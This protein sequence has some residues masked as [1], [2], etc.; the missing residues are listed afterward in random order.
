MRRTNK[1]GGRQPAVV[2]ETAS[3]TATDFSE[4]ST[5]APARSVSIPRLAYASR[6]WLPARML[7][8][9]CV[10][11]PQVRYPFPRLAYASRSW[12]R[13][14]CSVRNATFAMHKRTLTRAAGVSPPW[15]V[16]RTQCGENRPPFDDDATHE[17]ERR[18]SARRGTGNRIC[19][20]DRL[21]RTQHGRPSTVGFHPTAGL[22]QPLLVASADAVADVRFISESPL[23]TP[24]LAYTSRSWLHDIQRFDCWAY[25][26]GH[27]TSE[28]FFHPNRIKTTTLYPT[29]RGA[30]RT[31]SEKQSRYERAKKRG[32]FPGCS[33]VFGEAIPPTRFT[34]PGEFGS[35]G[36][37]R[38]QA[39]KRPPGRWL[40]P[41]IPATVAKLS[42]GPQKPVRF[43]TALF[44]ADRGPGGMIIVPDKCRLGLRSAKGGEFSL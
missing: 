25:P 24:R 27:K 9:M 39:E 37:A 7:L 11:Y 17:Q 10:S 2:P 43:T 5:F 42:N 31:Y 35:R 33:N 28:P 22:H 19:N 44:L 32:E 41:V 14:V 12:L 15:S 18:A 40:V 1:S 38:T 3:A 8:L 34:A 16:N 23:P 30:A 13:D 4:P 29:G 6:S 26:T 20:G 21:F 36:V